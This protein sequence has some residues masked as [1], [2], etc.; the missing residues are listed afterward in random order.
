M[1]T[2]TGIST[3]LGPPTDEGGGD[4][5]VTADRVREETISA[6]M[7]ALPIVGRAPLSR[8][9]QMAGNIAGERHSRRSV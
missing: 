6:K 9:G 8:D 4:K 2:G 5:V 7:T 1:G 3:T